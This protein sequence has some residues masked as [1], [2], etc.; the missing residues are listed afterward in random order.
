VRRVLQRL[1][2]SVTIA[3]NGVEVLT[4]FAPDVFDILIVGIAPP[5][6]DAL[7]ILGEVKR[8][9]PDT[10][11][12][13][14]SDAQRLDLA[15]AGMEQGAFAYLQTPLE[16]AAPL[17]YLVVRALEMRQLRRQVAAQS[18][19]QATSAITSAPELP[20]DLMHDLIEASTTQPSSE[21]MQVLAEAA[22]SL[23]ETEQA[24]VLLAPAGTEMQIAATFGPV[25]EIP[26]VWDFIYRPTDGFAYRVAT[27]H[28]TLI[29]AISSQELE[30]RPWQF[31]GTPLMSKDRVL[32][33]VVAY[34]LP[35]KP[36]TSAGVIWLEMLA[37]QGALAIELVQLRDENARL[38]TVD[39]A[40]GVLKRA[41]FLDQAEHEFRRSWRYNQPITA[42]IVDVDG[43]GAINAKHGHEFGDRV[44]RQVAHV[45]RSSLRSIDL[46]GHY[47][48][49]AFAL[50]LLMTGSES[51]RTVAERVRAAIGAIQIAHAQESV[52]VTASLGVCSY[53]RGGCASIFDLLAIAQETLRAAR[54]RGPNQIACG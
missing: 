1:G 23:V 20:F 11:V 15:R 49:D 9:S 37:M 26:T 44:L 34:P 38:S 16:D 31:I 13:L 29:D 30:G 32:G 27:A 24:I 45:C 53:P 8:R 28:K 17:G 46:V 50:L 6:F 47:D 48:G 4:R 36:V 12:I 41:V 54:R 2:C 3:Q 25:E 22:A 52:P 43:M 40:T 35:E 19:E 14:L 33:V 39:P 5:H 10:E 42:I 21:I 18:A 51:A 7:Q